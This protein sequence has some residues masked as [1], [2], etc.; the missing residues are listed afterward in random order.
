MFAAAGDEVTYRIRL[1]N[2]G[3]QSGNVRDYAGKVTQ[4]TDYLP[5]GLE[6]VKI[7]DEYQNKWK[8]TVDESNKKI[9]RIDATETNDQI[10]DP[11]CIQELANPEREGDESNYYQEIGVVCKVVETERDIITNRAEITGYEAY[12]LHNGEYQEVTD[13]EDRDSSPDDL[14]T[15]S[16]VNWY[17]ETVFNE[18]NPSA[19]YAGRKGNEANGAYEDDNDFDSIH[20]AKYGIQLTKHYGLP[21]DGSGKEN[22]LKGITFEVTKKRAKSGE[23]GVTEQLGDIQINMQTDGRALYRTCIPS[24]EDTRDEYKRNQSYRWI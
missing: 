9:I 21:T 11:N 17:N 10:L 7:E 2:E 18:N 13:I 5:D 15:E 16:L 1:Y 24:D 14:T 3:I 19:Y 23:E 20:I 12:E 22:I 8:A 6:F 4:V